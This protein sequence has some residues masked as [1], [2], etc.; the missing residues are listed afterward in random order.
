MRDCPLHL[1]GNNL[2]LNEVLDS[3]ENEVPLPQRLEQHGAGGEAVA[4]VLTADGTDF[5]LG[6][7]AGERDVAKDFSIYFAT[8][9][10]RRLTDRS[11]GS[12]DRY[13]AQRVV[14]QLEPQG[15]NRIGARVFALESA[16]PS[17]AISH[18]S[19]R[20]RSRLDRG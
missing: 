5:A 8:I 16:R 12:G 2:P 7:E 15:V 17:E 4:E 9:H 10:D 1:Y 14:E 18:R 19:P 13:V 6:E 3:V 20:I 11:P